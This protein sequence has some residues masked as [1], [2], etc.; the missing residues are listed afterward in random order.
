MNKTVAVLLALIM[1]FSLFAACSKDKKVSAEDFNNL[2]NDLKKD[3]NTDTD[4]SNTSTPSTSDN[5]TPDV[6]KPDTGASAETSDQPIKYLG[7]WDG[8]TFTNTW[9]DIS[10]N[11]PNSYERYDDD[12]I[13]S[14]GGQIESDT[15]TD[16]DYAELDQVIDT[17][18]NYFDLTKFGSFDYD[19]TVCYFNDF[20]GTAADFIQEYV[21]DEFDDDDYYD[22]TELTDTYDLSFGGNDYLGIDVR[23]FW[24]YSNDSYEITDYRFACRKIEKDIIAV[25]YIT[26]EITLYD[27]LDKYTYENP[28]DDILHDFVGKYSSNV[29]P[30][31]NNIPFSTSGNANDT[32][33]YSLGYVSNGIYYNNTCDIGLYF[34]VDEDI[35]TVF[36]GE[37]KADVFGD[38]TILGEN[39]SVN[40]PASVIGD[41][42]MASTSDTSFDRIVTVMVIDPEVEGESYDAYSLCHAMAETVE[43]EIIYES[44]VTGVVEPYSYCVDCF[45]SDMYYSFISFETNSEK[46]ILLTF[47]ADVEE[48]L[49]ETFYELFN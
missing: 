36:T 35:W 43:A 27:N 28:L 42:A 10:F 31:S 21:I 25:V 46:L 41:F 34:N 29:T 22:Y 49:D 4:V 3:N 17:N 39:Y 30:L 11:M 40:D 14:Q 19:F 6:D 47:F 32:G 33:D 45:D 23:E 16:E 37:D 9:S 12:E 38:S 13:L 24:E 2:Q 1:V 5:T 44:E 15:A 8:N 26:A 20:T 48:A 18:A 7:T